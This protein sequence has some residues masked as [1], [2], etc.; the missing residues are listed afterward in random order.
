MHFDLFGV[1]AVHP[2]ERL[3]VAAFDHLDAIRERARRVEEADRVLLCEFLADGGSGDAS[4][5]EVK[6]EPRA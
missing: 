6:G 4:A 3:S 2:A 1:N 5:A